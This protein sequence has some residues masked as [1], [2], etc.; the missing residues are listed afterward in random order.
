[1]VP[2]E[3]NEPK[4]PAQ[5]TWQG[6]HSARDS[7]AGDAGASWAED[8]WRDHMSGLSLAGL[9]LGEFGIVLKDMLL[10]LDSKLGRVANNIHGFLRSTFGWPQDELKVAQDLLPLPHVEMSV[11]D[12]KDLITH[13]HLGAFSSTLHFWTDSEASAQRL[14]QVSAWV[15]SI[16]VVVNHLFLGCG[17]ENPDKLKQA[18]APSTS[19]LESIWR[20]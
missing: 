1:M 16:I 15:F 5:V 2:S 10:E 19:Q 8:P 18:F 17:N 12:L 11:E 14:A 13:H 3:A 6:P 7:G 9:T 4:S 20:F